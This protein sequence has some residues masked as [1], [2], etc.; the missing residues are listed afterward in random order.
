MISVWMFNENFFGISPEKLSETFFYD[1]FPRNFAYLLPLIR[2]IFK[3]CVMKCLFRIFMLRNVG[4]ESTAIFQDLFIAMR[5]LW[6]LNLFFQSKM[7]VKT[8][9][10]PR[11]SEKVPRMTEKVSHR[12]GFD[13]RYSPS[14]Q[15]I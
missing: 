9:T 4:G 7:E 13:L 11:R 10:V 15:I 14:C 1:V 12:P 5:Y 3:F 6:K 2:A 8:K